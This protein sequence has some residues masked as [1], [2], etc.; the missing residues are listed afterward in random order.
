MN[1]DQL[2][3]TG[4]ETLILTASIKP[5]INLVWGGTIVMVL[6]FYFSLMARYKRMK[7][8]N[9]KHEIVNKNGHNGANGHTNKGVHQKKHEHIED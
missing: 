8:E 2:K 4:P 6:G 7:S 3:E 5:F 1:D 9:R